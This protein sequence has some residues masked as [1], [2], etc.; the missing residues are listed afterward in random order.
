ML[1]E[2]LVDYQEHHV[3]VQPLPVAVELPKSEHRG[4]YKDPDYP[5]RVIPEVF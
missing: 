3:G 1:R 4:Y 2:S 5:F